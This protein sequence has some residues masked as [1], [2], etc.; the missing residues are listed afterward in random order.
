MSVQNKDQWVRIGE[1]VSEYGVSASVITRWAQEK[2]I[3]RK[4]VDYGCT[5]WVYDKQHFANC[6]MKIRI[7]DHKKRITAYKKYSRGL[8]AA[9]KEIL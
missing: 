3:I 8:A 9:E 5:K 6:F 7:S 2:L 1:L 4:R